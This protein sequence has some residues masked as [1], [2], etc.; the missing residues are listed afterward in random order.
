MLLMKQSIN[1]EIEK[2]TL[3]EK[4]VG[5]NS[6]WTEDVKEFLKELK[7]MRDL[8]KYEG[9]SDAEKFINKINK[10]AGKELVK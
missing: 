8:D 10:L 1:M 2:M 7:D 4:I 9:N 6:L 5:G 3:S